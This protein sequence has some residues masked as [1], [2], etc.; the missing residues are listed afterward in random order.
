MGVLTFIYS[1]MSPSLGLKNGLFH[2]YLHDGTRTQR[3]KKLSIDFMVSIS[4]SVPGRLQ[5]F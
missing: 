4:G 1:Q 2:F 5:L 3:N